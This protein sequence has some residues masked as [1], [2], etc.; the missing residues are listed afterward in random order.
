MNARWRSSLPSGATPNTGRLLMTPFHHALSLQAADSHIHSWVQSAALHA[1]Q[2]SPPGSTCPSTTSPHATPKE[3]LSQESS[4]N[5]SSST[6]STGQA[7]STAIAKAA[8][9]GMLQAYTMKDTEGKLHAAAPAA[10]A[11]WA[12]SYILANRIS[13]SSSAA[14]SSAL[15]VSSTSVLFR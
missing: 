14:S 11:A 13:E 4:S 15:K 3:P 6:A 8:A 9:Q 7:V 2:C 12:T 5:G 10:V 1:A